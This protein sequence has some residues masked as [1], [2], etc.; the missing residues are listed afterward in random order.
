MFIILNRQRWGYFPIIRQHIYVVDIM[1]YQ[2]QGFRPRL[3][4]PGLYCVILLNGINAV[5]NYGSSQ[6]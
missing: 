1:N 4:K 2:K 5:P 3:I 6:Q